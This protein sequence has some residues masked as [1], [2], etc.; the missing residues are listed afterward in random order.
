M[1]NN[2][3]M[4]ILRWAIAIPAGIILWFAANHSIGTAFGILHGFDRVHDFWEAPDMDG[5]PII[6]TY[7][8]FITRTI[9][10]ASLVG[11]IIYIVPGHRK[12]VAIQATQADP[13]LSPD[14][15]YKH[16]LDMLSIMFGAI[17]GAWLAYT[18]QKRRI[19]DREHSE[20]HAAR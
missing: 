6:G 20:S 12:Q 15:W 16:I 4:N 19:V 9:S 5:V 13:G 8:I 17:A 14:G 3:A 18:S 7:I 10:A 1:R 2:P 11:V